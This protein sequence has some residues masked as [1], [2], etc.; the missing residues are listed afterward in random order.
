MSTRWVFLTCW[1]PG[2]PAFQKRRAYFVFAPPLGA[3][4]M[5]LEVSPVGHLQDEV[6]QIEMGNQLLEPGILL[7][8]FLHFHGL[9]DPHA[10]VLFAPAVVG[11]V[12]NPNFLADNGDGSS[13]VKQYFRF[14]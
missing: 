3:S 8:K 14:P 2:M 9:L 1:A 11:M 5:G 12:A 13:L 4:T 6:I 10:T 7:L